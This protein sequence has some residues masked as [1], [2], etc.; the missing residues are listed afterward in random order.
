MSRNDVRRLENMPPIPGGDI[1]TVQL[2]LVPLEDLRENNK[3]AQA[4]ALLELH[5][6]VFPDLP[7]EQSPLKKAA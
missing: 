4:K 7:Y 5:N 1:Y 2:N 3:A 6:F